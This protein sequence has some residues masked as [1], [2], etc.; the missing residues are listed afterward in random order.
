MSVSDGLLSKF[1]LAC[2]PSS[3]SLSRACVVCCVIHDGETWSN[4]PF[5]G[6]PASRAAGGGPYYELHYPPA[7]IQ[8]VVSLLLI[9][10][11]K[12]QQ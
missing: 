7:M 4:Q 11:P 1:P 9:P 6:F 10:V 3:A 12:P 5:K 2:A 8:P